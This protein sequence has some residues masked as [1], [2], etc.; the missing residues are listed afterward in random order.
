MPDLPMTPDNYATRPEFLAI[1]EDVKQIEKDVAVINARQATAQ[2][3]LDGIKQG[4]NDIKGELKT[5]RGWRQFLLTGGIGV[6]WG[7]IQAICHHYG[8][9]SAP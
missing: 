2:T 6:G 9:G 1:R 7:I 8:I 5:M 3:D 4:L